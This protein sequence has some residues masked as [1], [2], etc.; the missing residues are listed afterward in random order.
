MSH[1]DIRQSTARV[2]PD[3]SADL[4]G[5]EVQRCNSGGHADPP[6]REEWLQD[7]IANGVG[8]LRLRP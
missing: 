5:V 4:L 7:S 2:A 8:L 3:E 6:E 1:F